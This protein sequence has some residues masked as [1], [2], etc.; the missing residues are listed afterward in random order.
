MSFSNEWDVSY[1]KNTHLSIWPWSDLVSYV[2]RY[3]RPEN[4]KNCNVLEL[5]CGAGANI[6]F[7]KWLEVN[8]YAIEGSPVIVKMLQEKFPLFSENIKVGDFTKKISFSNNFD[9]VVDRASLTHNDTDSI[10]TCI[11]LIHSKMSKGASFIGID[12]FST[13]HSDFHGCTNFQDKFTC[14][15]LDAGQF[16]GVG[17]VHFSNK[18]HI[19]DLFQDFEIKLMEEKQIT[20]SIPV[21]N[22]VFAS[23]NIWAIK[24]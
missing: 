23:W 22:H 14:S 3:A 17:K 2:M 15:N 11:S 19:L 7:F 21:D 24:K 9:I 13:S 6:D 20:S 5:G 1:K 8:Y 12:W 10:R 4:P 16:K 18:E